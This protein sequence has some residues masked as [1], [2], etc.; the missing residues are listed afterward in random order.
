LPF[1]SLFSI[2]DSAVD[3]AIAKLLISN[4]A[5]VT[6]LAVKVDVLTV[7][8]VTLPFKFPDTLP[9][10]LPVILPLNPDD[11]VIVVPPIVVPDI[12]PPEAND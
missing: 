4:P 5:T 11:A 9:V 10:T 8:A 1:N 7:V 2:Y 6:L 12:A 3:I